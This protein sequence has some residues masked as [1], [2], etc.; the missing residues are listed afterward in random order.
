LP[1]LLRPGDELVVRKLDRLGR[2]VSHLVDAV[3][4]LADRGIHFIS[5]TEGFDTTT[6]AGLLLFGDAVVAGN[7][8]G[9]V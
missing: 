2:S 8:G 6:A 9:R 3:G 1:R 4:K 5:L 7:V